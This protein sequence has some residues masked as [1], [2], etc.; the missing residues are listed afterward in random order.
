MKKGF[1]I[2][3]LIIVLSVLVILIGIIIPRMSG[4]QQQGNIVK[5]KSELQT[6]MVAMEAYYNNETGNSKVY[7]ATHSKPCETYFV[8]ATPQIISS[9]L[10]DPFGS[11][12]AEYQLFTSTPGGKYYTFVSKGPNGQIDPNWSVND[13]DGSQ[14]P[15]NSSGYICV[16]N[17]KGC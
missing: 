5:A 14:V 7:P 4:M 3:E 15:G 9:V 6:L 11:N 16:T 2:I 13:T 1:T 8:T 17:G 10:Y 12:S